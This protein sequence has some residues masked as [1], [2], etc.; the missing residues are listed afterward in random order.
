MPESGLKI[1]V[2][3]LIEL[4]RANEEL[5]HTI[6]PQN[7]LGRSVKRVLT[8]LHKY[9]VRITHRQ[10]GALASSHVMEFLV[11][12]KRIEGRL[13]ISRRT[14][15]PSTGARPYKYGVEEHE[16]GGTH[17][18]YRRTVKE[19]GEQAVLAEIAALR[20][21]SEKPFQGLPRYFG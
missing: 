2:E 15:N 16:R 8:F 10:T 1:T 3:G 20:R 17:A 5:I 6:R 7:Q 12:R 14:R 21:A 13:F 11:R 18:F 9:A 19:V 4:Q